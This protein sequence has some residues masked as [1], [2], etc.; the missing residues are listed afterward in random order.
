MSFAPNELTF[1]YN[2]SDILYELYG[3]ATISFEANEIELGLGEEENP[4]VEIENGSL[5]SLN[6]SITSEFELSEA[7]TAS[8]GHLDLDVIRDGA[9]SPVEIHVD[10]A[11]LAVQ[12]Y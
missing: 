4:G 3:G 9:D 2:K 8:D 5:R 12:S 11:R 6:A 7:I 10:L 1:V